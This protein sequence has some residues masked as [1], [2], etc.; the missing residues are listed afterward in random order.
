M[1]IAE[2]LTNLNALRKNTD[3][4]IR[5]LTSIDSMNGDLAVN[6]PR[7]MKNLT[8]LDD[9]SNECSEK[10]PIFKVI[11]TWANAYE[12]EIET[13]KERLKDRFGLLLEN[14][15]KDQG[16]TLEGNFPRFTAGFFTIEVDYQ[17]W[18]TKIWYGPRQELLDTSPFSASQVAAY[19]KGARERLGSRLPS[20]ELLGLLRSTFFEFVSSDPSGA[21]SIIDLYEGLA[22]KICPP[23]QDAH[24]SSTEHKMKDYGRADFSYDLFRVQ[25]LAGYPELITATRA[26]TK[27]RD[28]FLWVPENENGKGTTYSHIRFKER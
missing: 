27:K 14:L 23:S 6:L 18:S 26:F 13:E 16:Y 12:Q 5:L 9:L 17:K 25:G 11:S 1:D 22:Q 4:A 15:L 19:I 10:N 20:N 8:K 28:G 2:L 24:S 21:V 7:L 3:Q